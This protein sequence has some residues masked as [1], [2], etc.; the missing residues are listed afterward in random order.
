MATGCRSPVL[1]RR[2]SAARTGRRKT[3]ESAQRLWPLLAP[4][5]LGLVIAGGESWADPA[6][7]SPNGLPVQVNPTFPEP[8]LP[9]FSF[10]QGGLSDTGGVA[11]A[12]TI[13]GGSGSG[14]GSGADSA[15]LG[16]YSGTGSG[17]AGAIIATGYADLLGQ[18]VGTGECVALA[19]ATSDVGYTSTWSPGAQVQGD[20]DIAVGTVIATFGSDGTYTNTYGQ[21]HTAIYLGQD[22]NGIYVEDQWLGQAAQVR[23]I[24]WTTRNTYE[25]GSQFYVVAHN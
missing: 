22:S 2:A 16:S 14:S 3:R 23:H 13:G 5:G 24:A 18:S 10:P 15:S 9:A 7:V 8:G 6:I 1:W 21:S 17:V 25:S 11:G 19:Q 4:V 12:V 20:T